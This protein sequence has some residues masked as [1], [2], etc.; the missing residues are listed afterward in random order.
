MICHHF[1]VTNDNRSEISPGN[2]KIAKNR[3]HKLGQ[4]RKVAGKIR[5]FAHMRNG[6]CTGR[7]L[8]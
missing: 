1:R 3:R 4:R 5:R 7:S 8:E 2:V 6:V